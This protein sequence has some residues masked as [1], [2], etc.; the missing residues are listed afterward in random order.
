MV[1]NAEGKRLMEWIE[2][3]GSEVLNGNKEGDEEW[4]WTYVDSRR[5]RV[6]DYGITCVRHEDTTKYAI[7]SRNLKTSYYWNR[8]SE[9][10]RI[11]AD[12]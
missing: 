4:E 3:H 12:N 2:E 10:V 11:R 5:E 8:I 9:C 7:G 6:I 1:E